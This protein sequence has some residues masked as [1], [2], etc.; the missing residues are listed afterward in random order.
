VA[1]S[2]EPY[3]PRLRIGGPAAL[4]FADISGYT[5]LTERLA[6]SGRAGAE[7]VTQ[8]VN[9]CFTALITEVAVGGGDVVRFGGD[10]LFVAFAGD[11]RVARAAGTAARMQ[12]ALGR[13]GAVS[14]PGGRVRLRMS[15]GLHHG[16][17]VVH[18]WSGSWCERLPVGPAVTTTLRLE[19]GAAAGQVRVSPEVAASLGR[20]LVA[21]ELLRLPAA[22]RLA[23]E[24]GHGPIGGGTRSTVP[25]S[26]RSVLARG[27]HAEHRAASVAFVLLPGTDVRAHASRRIDRLLDAVD[28]VSARLGVVPVSTDVA[29]NGVK[30]IL[31]TGVPVA[32]EDDD[33]RLLLAAKSVV[34]ACRAARAGVHGGLVF[35]G[36]VGHPDRRTFTVMGDTVNLAARLMGNARAG[37]VLAS[38]SFVESLR[39]SFV[40]RWRDPFAVKGKAALQHAA[41]VGRPLPALPASVEPPLCG[42]RDEL[43]QVLRMLSDPGV[44]EVTGPSGIGTTR[45]V[46][47]AIRRSQ[48]EAVVVTASVADRGVPL[49]VAWRAAAAVGAE[50]NV[51]AR[52]DPAAVI[53]AM[54]QALATR[55][56]VRPAAVLVI[57]RSQHV[58]GATQSVLRGLA[59]VV[60][61]SGG[62]V[63]VCGRAPIVDRSSA[64]VL[65]PLAAGDLRDVAVGA[66]LR[67]LS[68]AELDE[69]VS[70]AAG[71]PRFAQALARLDRTDADMPAS[72]EAL[73]ASRL[74]A[75]H[76]ALRTIVREA[77]LVGAVIDLDLL[78]TVTGRSTEL[79]RSLLARTGLVALSATT[80]N[81]LDDTVRE[82]AAAGL[83]MTARRPLHRAVARRLAADPDVDPVDVA[84]HCHAG[85]D[86]AGTEVWAARAARTALAGGA[87]AAAA[88]QARRAVD[89]AQRFGRSAAVVAR[90]ATLWSD[91]AAAAGQLGDTASAL[92]LAIRHE[93]H[94]NRRAELLVAR[95]RLARQDGRWRAAARFLGTAR[96]GATGGA[97]IAVAIEGGFLAYDTGHP[98]KAQV[99]ARQAADAARAGRHY[100]LLARALGLDELVRSTTGQSGWEEVGRMALAAAERSGDEVLLARVASNVAMTLDNRGRWAEALSLY[101]EVEQRC[102][103]AGQVTLAAM[104]VRNRATIQVELGDVGSVLD[105]IGGVLRVVAAAGDREGMAIAEALRA[106]SLARTAAPARALEPILAAVASL[107]RR[108]SEVAVFARTGLA[109]VLLLANRNSEA[110]ELLEELE[111]T[112]DQFGE[113]HLLPLTVRRLRAVAL[114]RCGDKAGAASLLRAAH[115]RAVAGAVLAEQCF[116]HWTAASLGVSDQL[117]LDAAELASVERTLGVVSAIRW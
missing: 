15:V 94:S 106:R 53:D 44:Y 3:G 11:D 10:A 90:L 93:G 51:P 111:A 102:R 65:G 14:V 59:T 37:E 43:R 7:V 104:M 88:L 100:A 20:H 107:P 49:G 55:W 48:R 77:A 12:T 1:A 89:A 33:E 38:R 8:V 29:A 116:V 54:V 66:S 113:D 58:D 36:D 17:L 42:R 96:A 46:L 63:V 56:R 39:A 13:L 67:P 81:F 34:G 62:R 45:L 110:L 103:A 24:R 47:E 95:A 30:V 114:S 85:G 26:L 2:F 87:S 9:E 25:A 4:L 35:C 117:G 84:Y 19:A 86:D 69:I 82:V 40:L 73:V 23:G 92:A 18:E 78:A 72:L 108:D 79:V 50:V 70:R 21:G 68:D 74:D 115:A 71:N 6:A 99:V 41:V 98:E 80:A 28:D 101:A 75:L 16:E 5:R 83:P 57:R 52:G 91:A 112:V 105:V 32:T 64:V 27:A 60:S 109:E 22:C 76:P 31:A 97:A 61:D